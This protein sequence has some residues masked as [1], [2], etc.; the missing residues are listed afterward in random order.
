MTTTLTSSAPPLGATVEVRRTGPSLPSLV[1]LEVRKSLSSRSGIAIA[2]SAVVMGPSGLLLAALDA[3]FGWVA[4]PMGVVAMMTGLVLLALG[5][6]S[7]AGEWTH[8]TV[9]TTYL[10]VPRRG[11]VLAAKS[12]AVALLG[13]ALA[14][15]SA[16][17]SLAVIAAVG[18]DYLNWDGWVQ[19]T[20]VTLA[21]GAVF[22]VIGAG[23]GAATANTTAALTVLYLFIMGV[24]PLVRVGKPELGDAVDPAHATMLL[25]QGMEETRSIL[26]L[27]GWV[28][29]SSVAGWTLTHRRPV[30]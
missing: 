11:L 30:Q 26:I 3:E 15:V 20:V 29:V 10:L 17:L 28:V 16:A 14:A 24:L 13:A 4:A 27:A 5:V 9:Q 2:A 12:V 1:G 23:I 22:A 19:A 21:A 7:T 25:A 6:V 18:V 8:G